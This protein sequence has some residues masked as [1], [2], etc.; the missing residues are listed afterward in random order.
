M[1]SKLIIVHLFNLIHNYYIRSRLDKFR[2]DTLQKPILSIIGAII[3]DY[4]P[5]FENYYFYTSGT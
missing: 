1:S 3:R 4:Q 5:L 2:D